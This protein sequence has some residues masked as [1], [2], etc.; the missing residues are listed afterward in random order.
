MKKIIGMWNVYMLSTEARIIVS[1]TFLYSQ[2]AF[3]GSLYPIDQE[4]LSA[5]KDLISNFVNNNLKVP[6]HM[7]WKEKKRGRSWTF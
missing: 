7:V 5:I 4:S 2:L 1:K 6:E 3:T